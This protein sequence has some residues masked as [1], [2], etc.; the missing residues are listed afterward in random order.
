[1]PSP[2]FS[3]LYKYFRPRSYP[4]ATRL[5][6]PSSIPSPC[7]FHQ[8]S[9]AFGKS[10]IRNPTSK[11]HN[12][13]CSFRVIHNPTSEIRNFFSAIDHRPAMVALPFQFHYT[14]KAQ[15]FRVS[16]SFV[17][18]REVEEDK[19]EEEYSNFAIQIVLVSIEMKK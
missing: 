6:A 19:Q 8:P 10:A 7:S 9:F 13:K 1:M 2:Y 16:G 12:P 3:I 5:F 14:G 17:A 18:V 15:A 11:I 4:I